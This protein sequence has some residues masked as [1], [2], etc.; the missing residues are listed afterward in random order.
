MP[1][2]DRRTHENK[3]PA[4]KDDAPG[5]LRIHDFGDE[6][7]L[8]VEQRVSWKVALEILQELK[9]PMLPARRDEDETT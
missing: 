9:A 6:V 4:K 3:S 8:W 1:D 7:H 5:I 2:R